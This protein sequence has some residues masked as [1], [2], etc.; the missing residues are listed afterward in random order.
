MRLQSD[1]DKLRSGL[2]T[3]LLNADPDGPLTLEQSNRD[4]H[5]QFAPGLYQIFIARWTA[6]FRGTASRSWKKK[7]YIR[8]AA[9]CALYAAIWRSALREAAPGVLNYPE[10]RRGTVRKRILS[11][12]DELLV[13]LGLFEN[14]QLTIGLGK[15]VEEP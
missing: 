3:H 7:N 10:E 9:P 11:A 8:Y 5:F 13:Q 4:Y 6:L 15:A 12:M 14:T 2:F 1:I